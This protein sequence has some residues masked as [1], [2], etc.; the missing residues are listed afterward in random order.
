ML[1]TGTAQAQTSPEEDGRDVTNP[2]WQ[3]DW[4]DPTIWRGD[5]GRYHCLATNPRR[6]IVSD[7]LFHWEMSSVSPIDVGSWGTMQ[8]VA[9]RF[10]APDVATVAGKRNLYLTLYNS[11]EDSKIG[12]LQ[13]FAPGQFSY[14]GIITSSTETGIHDTI[15]PE[16]VTDPKTVKVWLFFGSVGGIHRVELTKDGLACKPKSRYV[17][18][19]GLKVQQCPDRSKVFEG[20]YLHRHGKYWYLFVSSGFFGDHTYQLKVGR[21]KSLTDDFLDR[22]GNRMAEGFATPVLH[23]DKGDRFYGPGHCGEIFK[24]GDGKEY[25]FYHCHVEGSRRPGSRPLFIAPIKWDKEGWP[26]VE[27]GKPCE[28]LKG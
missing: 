14:V 12:V 7:D 5:D 28:R 22:D 8:A 3:R 6:S 10:W 23:S 2:V 11:A 21:A 17:H 13:E 27:G 15:D 16:V 19:A 18:V 9:E 26:Y 4:P 20:S 25:I 1:W 24:A